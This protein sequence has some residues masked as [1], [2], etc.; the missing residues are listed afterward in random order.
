MVKAYSGVIH[1]IQIEELLV[2]QMQSILEMQLQ[3]YEMQYE[4]E[5]RAKDRREDFG[6]QNATKL[7]IL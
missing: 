6:D 3:Q 2:L 7:Q 4:T 1:H 5:A